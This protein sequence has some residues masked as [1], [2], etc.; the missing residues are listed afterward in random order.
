MKARGPPNLSAPQC[1]IQRLGNYADWFVT[2]I[3]RP[4]ATRSA[5]KY[6]CAFILN[7]VLD[8]QIFTN[9]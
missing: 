1:N 7:Q 9:K 2:N 5:E 4:S 3:N 6:N 8:G